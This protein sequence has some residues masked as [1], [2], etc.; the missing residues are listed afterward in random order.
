MTSP[1][2]LPNTLQAAGSASLEDTLRSELPT[3]RLPLERF[4][5]DGGWPINAE[6]RVRAATMEADSLRLELSVTF[7]EAI[8]AC[9][10][11]GDERPRLGELVLVVDRATA[12]A[13]FEPARNL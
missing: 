9:G 1:L 12:L 2:R 13:R 10:G 8:S 6:L 5:A 11:S 4:L 7:D 3:A